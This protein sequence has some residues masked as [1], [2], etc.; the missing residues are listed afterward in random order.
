MELVI[1]ECYTT[2][3]V[4]MAHP[5]WFLRDDQGKIIPVDGTGTHYYIDP[6]VAAARAWWQS[7]PVQIFKV[8]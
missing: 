6:T 5:E 3:D 1:S 2:A 4:F 8:R 7:V